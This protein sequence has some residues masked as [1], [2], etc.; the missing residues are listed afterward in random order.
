M[1][2]GWHWWWKSWWKRDIFSTSLNLFQLLHVKLLILI[3]LHLLMPSIWC[4][5][6][7]MLIVWN[8]WPMIS[9]GS[10]LLA[11]L[12]RMILNLLN[13]R[14]QFLLLLKSIA[15]YSIR[16]NVRFS[17]DCFLAILMF[18]LLNDHNFFHLL[19]RDCTFHIYPFVLNNMLMFE[20]QNNVDT[21]YVNKSDKSKTTRLM[22]PLIL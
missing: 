14:Q 5:N 17:T 22:C 7:V 6:H 3:L 1:I 12:P 15:D 21:S 20:P 10:S 2:W 8:W 18:L 9:K 4:S 11:L 16:L 19:D 13:R